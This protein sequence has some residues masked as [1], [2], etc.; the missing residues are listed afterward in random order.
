[1]LIV[2]ANLMRCKSA[3]VDLHSHGE[4]ENTRCVEVYS[5]S[6]LLVRDA[7]RRRPDERA[8]RCCT[9]R[10]RYESLNCLPL[11]CGVCWLGLALM[12]EPKKVWPVQFDPRD[13]YR[14]FWPRAGVGL[15]VGCFVGAGYGVCFG[16][17]RPYRF[18]RQQCVVVP[19][20]EPFAQDGLVVGCF[21]GV[22]FGI[23]FGSGVARGIGFAWTRKDLLNFRLRSIDYPLSL[24]TSDLETDRLSSDLLNTNQ[25]FNVATAHQSVPAFLRLAVAQWLKQHR[26]EN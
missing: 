24:E 5:T 4:S 6:A 11:N 14:R 16:L 7:W 23:G 9:G 15:S 3:Y 17:G 18:R 10:K 8:Q 20:L 2:Y 19:S 21:C 25:A 1:M 26:A 13:N 12:N 22:A